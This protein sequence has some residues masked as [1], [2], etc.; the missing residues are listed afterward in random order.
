MLNATKEQQ[1]FFNTRCGRM[2]Y[3]L[4]EMK[5]KGLRFDEL[6]LKLPEGIAF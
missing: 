4:D 6:V 1:A 2:M 5:D 3:V